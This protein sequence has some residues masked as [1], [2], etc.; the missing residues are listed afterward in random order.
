MLLLQSCYRN[1]SNLIFENIAQ[2]TGSRTLIKDTTPIGF[3]SL[4]KLILV[5]KC[6]SCHSGPE[7]KPESD[8][9]DFSSYESTMIDRFIPLIVKGNPYKGRLFESVES[10]EMPPKIRLHA[11]EID[12]I[13]KWIEA[14]APKDDITEMPSECPDDD[15]GDDDW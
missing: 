1:K 10:G 15:G 14:C 8:P 5:P 4:K 2:I 12:F 3:T 13:K 7:A 11:R 6:I 9:I